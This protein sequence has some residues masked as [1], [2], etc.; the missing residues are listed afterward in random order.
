LTGKKVFLALLSSMLIGPVFAAGKNGG[1]QLLESVATGTDIFSIPLIEASSDAGKL[2]DIAATLDTSKELRL[3]Y[4]QDEI[5]GKP[6]GFHE[7]WGYALASRLYEFDPATMDVT[8][9]CLFGAEINSYGELVNVPDPKKV[10]KYNGRKHLVVACDS[11]SLTHFVLD[12]QFGLRQ[13]LVKKLAQASKLYDGVQIDFE[14]VPARDAGN[15]RSFLSDVRVAIGSE[16]W[17]TV[18]LPARIKNIKD[19]IYSYQKI[20]PLVDRIIV[21]AYDEHWSTSAPGSIASMDWCEKI[22]DYSK[23]VIPAKKL[24]MGLPFYGRIWEDGSVASAWYFT[25]INRIMNEN[26]IHEI[27][28]ENDIPKFSFTQTVKVTGYFEDT[29]SLVKRLKMYEQKG[30]RKVAFWRIG[31]EDPTF[32]DWLFIN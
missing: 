20:Y 27:E 19:D 9:L 25:G 11:R 13:K 10:K 6:V 2:L 16:K 24:V 23:G 15:F 3:A 26:N 7:V 18:A 5:E 21:M 31:Q 1:E 30:I 32:W 8:D 22:A 17:M 14:L 28:R 4:E 29:Y 12:P